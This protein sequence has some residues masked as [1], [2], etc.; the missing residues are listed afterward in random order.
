[1]VANP[2]LL[3]L[4]EPTNGLDPIQVVEIR[5]LI[6]T[7]GREKT[8][9]LTTHVLSEVEVLADRVVL[10][11]Q[12]KVSAEGSLQEVT[13]QTASDATTFRVCISGSEEDLKKL[14]EKSGAHWLEGQSASE[15]KNA[16]GL[17]QA[18]HGSYIADAAAALGL[19]LYELTPRTGNLESLFHR[20]HD[21]G[22]SS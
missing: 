14:A 5:Q 18:E 2:S 1:L 6:R 17:M 9:I 21:G 20:L 12:G 15:P 3:I 22:L 11:H 4:D 10:L 8:V 16:A 13:Q 19:P 7:L